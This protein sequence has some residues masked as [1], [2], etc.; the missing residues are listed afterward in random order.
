MEEIIIET[1][2][3][4]ALLLFPFWKVYSRA[5]LNPYLSLTLLIPGFGLLIVSIIL[6]VSKWEINTERAGG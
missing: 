4:A 5:G 6:A 1:I 2:I 3:L